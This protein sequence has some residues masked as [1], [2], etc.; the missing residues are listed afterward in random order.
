MDGKDGRKAQYL[1]NIMKKSLMI[2]PFLLLGQGLWAEPQEIGNEVREGEFR[3]FHVLVHTYFYSTAADARS[4]GED[5]RKAFDSNFLTER[6]PPG[7][8]LNG[9]SFLNF[10]MD[11][12][13]FSREPSSGFTVTKQN[14]QIGGNH[15]AYAVI[16]FA[17][18]GRIFVI[19]NAAIEQPGY[20]FWGAFITK[21]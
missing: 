21:K 19:V 6:I 2:L 9:W 12:V 3:G 11:A 7:Q 5:T 1:P 14:G 8:T 10:A 4:V 15:Q 13:N 17:P 18:V 20:Y 16:I